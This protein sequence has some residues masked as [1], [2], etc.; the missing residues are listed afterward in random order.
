[1]VYD[2][3]MGSMRVLLTTPLP[4]WFL[5]V[6]RLFAGVIVSLFQVYTF[7]LVAYFCGVELPPLGYLTALPALVLSGMMFGALGML[8]SSTIKQL[9]NFAGIMNF[10][11]FPMFFASSAL[12][13]LW[14]MREGSLWLYYICL[15]NPFTWAV[16]LIRFA[17]YLQINW[18][19]LGIVA[20]CTLLFLALSVWAY[21][22]S[23]GIQQRKVGAAAAAG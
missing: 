23:F 21:D 7:L 13:P 14:K 1:M 12:Y 6:S 22:P 2:R 18:E 4:R 17:F 20:G 19:A 10:V 15:Y 16:E 3:E 9:E 5:L 11:I 8:L